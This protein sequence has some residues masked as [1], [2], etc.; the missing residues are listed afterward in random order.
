MAEY[1]TREAAIELLHYNADETCSAVVSDFEAIPSVDI[2]RPTASQ[3]K[4]MA[5]QMDYAPVVHGRWIIGVDNDDFDVK[6]SKCEWTDIF[7]VAG[8]SAVERIAKAMHYCPNCGAKM[9]GND[10]G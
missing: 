9:D 3:F 5:A 10:G 6:C 1:I 2:D 8:I 4:R 7:E